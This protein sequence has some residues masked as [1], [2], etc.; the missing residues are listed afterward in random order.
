[1][2]KNFHLPGGS[3]GTNDVKIGFQPLN[4]IA[5]KPSQYSGGDFY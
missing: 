3:E 4:T 2:Q 5:M 1:M